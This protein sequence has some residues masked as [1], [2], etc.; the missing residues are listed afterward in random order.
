MQPCWK[1]KEILN[2]EFNQTQ[3]AKDIAEIKDSV[4]DLNNKFDDVLEKLDQKYAGKWVEISIKRAVWII[5][6]IVISSIVYQVI[7]K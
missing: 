4:K 3:M 1:E 2:L 5:M 7:I 6:W